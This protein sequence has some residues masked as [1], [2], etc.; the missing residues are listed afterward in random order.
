MNTT[1]T[2]ELTDERHPDDD[3]WNPGALVAVAL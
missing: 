1:Q 2:F 3:H